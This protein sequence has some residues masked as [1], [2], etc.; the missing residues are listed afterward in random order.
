M[1]NEMGTTKWGRRRRSRRRGKATEGNWASRW[2]WEKYS[3]W[4]H[5]EPQE[6][7]RSSSTPRTRWRPDEPAEKEER[8]I[9]EYDYSIEE[10][11]LCQTTL[12]PPSEQS[13]LA[14]EDSEPWQIDR[15][16]LANDGPVL[17]PLL[18]LGSTRNRTRR[19][20]VGERR[21]P[22][23]ECRRQTEEEDS[24][25]LPATRAGVE[26]PLSGDMSEFLSAWEQTPEVMGCR[27]TLRPTT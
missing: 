5:M 7:P 3:C 12:S 13:R 11:S 1:W 26:P 18:A 16:S 14:S 4:G 27:R 17:P 21:Q 6:R 22:H 8:R 9:P 23:C 20:V 24:I 10:A 25:D 19:W 2:R 15:S